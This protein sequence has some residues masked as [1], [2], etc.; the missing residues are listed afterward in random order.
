MLRTAEP[1]SPRLTMTSLEALAPPELEAPGS[2]SAGTAAAANAA[3]TSST[4]KCG[5]R[6]A[7]KI[8]A[9]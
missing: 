6:T 9:T 2:A 5:P 4:A 7:S 1:R 8:L 3:S